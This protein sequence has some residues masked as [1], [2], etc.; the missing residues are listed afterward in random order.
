MYCWFPVFCGI[1]QLYVGNVPYGTFSSVSNTV[2]SSF[3]HTTVYS[4]IVSL[5]CAVYTI[6]PA[7]LE[8]AGLHQVNEYV[9]WAVAGFVGVSQVYCGVAP[10]THIHDWST[11]QS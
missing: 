11:D 1:V 4:F 6:S 10:N 7:T 2:Q 3:F 5:N 9:Y 8:T